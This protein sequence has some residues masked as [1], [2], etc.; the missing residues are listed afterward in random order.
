MTTTSIRKK[1]L[2]AAAWTVLAAGGLLLLLLLIL[3]RQQAKHLQAPTLEAFMHAQME[4]AAIPGLA[5]A[6]IRDSRVALA[7]TYGYADVERRKP[8]TA[9][10]PF[11]IASISKPVLGV[12]LLQLAATG[13]LDLDRDINE[14]LHFTVANPH[15]PSAPITVRQLATHT[16]GIAD[17]DDPGS[18]SA[19]V[20][21][22]VSLEDHLIQL[23][24]PGGRG[25]EQGA[26]F[27]E[28]APGTRREYSNLGAA[29]AG[30]VAESVAG[31]HLDDYSR[32]AV[33]EP[34]HMQHSGWRLADFDL[35]ELAVPYE[36]EQCV[37]YTPIC[38]DSRSEVVNTI[39][40][41]AFDPPL[42]FKRFRPYPHF[43]NPQYPDGGL[44]TSL[45]DLSALAIALLDENGGGVLSASERAELLRPQLPPEI[46]ARQ[47]FFLRADTS[48]RLGH[49]GSDLGVFTSFY[50]DP[51]RKDAVI[52][53][54]NRTFDL[55]TETA[56]EEISARLWALTAPESSG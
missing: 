11:N 38:S 32:R 22:A 46:D 28:A 25:Y 33:F 26:Y 2:F 36:V 48:G 12:I 41:K 29:L 40:S 6:V 54:M 14:Y 7:K 18:Y 20:D 13:R 16:A 24:T 56:M 27:L 31:E 30:R 37:P 9:D 8:V 5:V 51:E 35:S 1:L 42:E 21:P 47:R 39:I 15:A 55:R 3:P 52:I 17:N 49:R 10:T 45:N 19:N 34:L 53:L 50:L 44:R 23:L 4:E 43:G